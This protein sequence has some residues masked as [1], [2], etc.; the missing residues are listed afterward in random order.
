MKRLIM[1][2]VLMLALIVSTS[3]FAWM[4]YWNNINPFSGGPPEHCPP[5]QPGSLIQLINAGPNW[6]VDD[7]IELFLAEPNPQAALDAWLLAGTP[8]VS[9]D[10]L[11]DQTVF[12]DFGPGYEGYFGK[13]I[14]G[15]DD[16]L[17]DPW[18]TRYFTAAEREIA[19]CDWYGEV[20]DGRNLNDPIYELILTGWNEST[21]EYEFGDYIIRI[22]GECADKHIK[23][24]PEPTTMAIGGIA[25]LLG[26]LRRKVRLSYKA[27]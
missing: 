2:P 12:L 17:G 26:F 14:T 4:G 19:K 25:L 9:D 6:Q 27:L 15:T 22:E 13:Q 10:T 16:E 5:I 23:I 18:Y 24:I 7:P 3:A 20:G 11:R 21:L 8:P 1:I